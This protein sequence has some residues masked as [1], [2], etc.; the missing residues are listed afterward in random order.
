MLKA[1]S[2]LVALVG[3]T[4]AGCRRTPAPPISVA[5]HGAD[6]VFRFGACGQPPQRIMNL[7][8]AEAGAAEPVCNLVLTHDPKMTIAGEWRYGDVPPAYKSKRCDPLVPGRSYRME[9]T[10]ATLDF[11]LGREGEVTATGSS[12]R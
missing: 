4:A 3:L 5:R 10:R 7:V 2:L 12:C 9:V 11:Q 6:L 1:L 8:V